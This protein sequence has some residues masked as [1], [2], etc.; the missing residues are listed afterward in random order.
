MPIKITFGNFKGGVG[1]T[2]NSV[3]SA[4]ELA[5][6]GYKVLVCDLD[7]QANSTQLLSR[8][9]YAQNNDT[10]TMNKSMMV[11]IQEEDLK[12]AVVEIMDNLFLLPSNKDFVSYPDFLELL[13]PA[14]KDRTH[15]EQRI[16]YFNDLLKNIE[17][18][19]DYIIFDVPPTLSVF[20]DTALFSSN[21]IMIV[22]QTQQRSLDGAE[23]FAEYLQTMYDTY[24]DIDIDIAGVLPVLMKNDSRMDNQ[25]ITDSEERFGKEALFE[26]VIKHMERLKR[27]DRLGI[28][29]EGFTEVFD[30]HD[31]KVHEV[32]SE[33]VDELIKRTTEGE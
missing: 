6:K 27:Y 18:D 13:F 15:K 32:Y 9:Y 30:M 25:I 22:L 23:A 8:T 31:K 24:D 29:E 5:R 11:A 20:T 7:P 19:Y 26:V 14:T 12:S 33:F 2:T 28:H 1:K 21:N 16:S 4:Y 10:L 3:M 17:D